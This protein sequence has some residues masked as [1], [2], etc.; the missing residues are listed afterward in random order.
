MAFNLTRRKFLQSAS[1]AAVAL[2]LS[3]AIAS[4]SGVTRSPFEPKGSLGDKTVVG[5]ICEMC[6]WRCQLIGKTRDKMLANAVHQSGREYP[7]MKPWMSVDKN[8]KLLKT[9]MVPRE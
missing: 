3:K 5:G 9:N 8:S 4:E 1:L 7:G 2:P 6:F